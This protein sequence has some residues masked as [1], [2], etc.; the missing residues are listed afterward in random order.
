MA[1]PT[2][3]PTAAQRNKVAIAA[4]AGM[5]HEEIAI[6]LGISRNTLEKYFEHELS[7]GAYAKRL[8]VLAAMHAAAK[9][10]NVAAQKAYTSMPA[11]RAA[12][13][14]LPADEA[15]QAK[16]RASAKGKKEQAQ[17]EAITAQAGTEWQDL[18]PASSALQ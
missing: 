13:T 6:G 10:G 9:K 7:H 1:R 16:G 11:P 5:S 18:L 17:A 12:A 4:G 3:K 15:P 14:P 2:F 8:E